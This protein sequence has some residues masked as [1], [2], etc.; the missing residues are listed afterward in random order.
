MDISG[1]CGGFGARAADAG[2]LARGGGCGGS[3][4]RSM[5]SFVPFDAGFGS[6]PQFSLMVSDKCGIDF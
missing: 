1:G 4:R 3:A 6:P 2:D 5:R